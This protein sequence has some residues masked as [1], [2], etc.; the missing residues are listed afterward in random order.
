MDESVIPEE[1]EPEPEGLTRR[2]LL[3]RTAAV[4][5][6]VTALGMLEI[7]PALGAG[8]DKVRWISP[9]GTLDVMD[10]F[11][12]WVPITLGY[13]RKLNIDVTLAPGDASGNL[14]Q[15]AA[16]QVDMGYPSP[17]VLTSSID[18]G[19]PVISIWEQYPAQVFDFVLP[20]KSKITSP[21]QLAGKSIAVFTIGWK[22]IV[23]PMLAEVGVNTKT[24]KYRELGAA[25]VQAVAQGQADAG[26][27]WEGLRA[28][29]IGQSSTFGSAFAL[30]FLVGS[31]WGSKGPSNTYV[32]RTSDYN[33]A[34]K[35]DIYTRFLAGSVYGSEFA[36]ANPRAAAQ[37]TYGARPALQQLISAQVA[38]V[39]MMQLASGYSVFRRN[40]PHLYGWHDQ[41]AWTRYLNAIS[42]LGQTKQHLTV[43]QVLTNSMVRAANKR[44]D[45]AAARK[46]A[47]AYKLNSIFKNTKVPP[48]YP[49]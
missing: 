1:L 35:R 44:A 40:P 21:K 37:I 13:F 9:R 38:L 12:L 42:K 36:R 30:K 2:D 6:G 29:L 41:V 11:N 16:N 43:N 17:G 5:A 45:V 8:R 25:W 49:L 14:P 26:L 47:K 31:K 24:V 19:V 32:I 22:S 20:A 23:D 4:G 18:A 28:Q 3:K 33:D 27:V 39:S 46:A 48:G 7:E 34:K 10:D 15:V